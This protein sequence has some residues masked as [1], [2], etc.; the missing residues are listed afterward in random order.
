MHACVVN[1]NIFIQ[2]P[3]PALT[4]TPMPDSRFCLFRHGLHHNTFSFF[5]PFFSSFLLFPRADPRFAAA[6]QA[7]HVA[8]NSLVLH[9]YK[10]PASELFEAR[11]RS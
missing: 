7:A 2:S 8:E 5:F 1:S 10:S 9:Q 4:L 11:W 3:E 6:S